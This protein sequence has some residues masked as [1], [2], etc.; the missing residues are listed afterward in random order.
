MEIDETTLIEIQ[1]YINAL[2]E[3]VGLQPE[4][5]ADVRKAISRHKAYLKSTRLGTVNAPDHDTP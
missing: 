5:M 2:D 4:T 1:D 3:K